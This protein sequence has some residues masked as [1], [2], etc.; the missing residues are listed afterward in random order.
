MARISVITGGAGGIGLACARRLA[1]AGDVVVLADLDAGRGEASARALREE[2]AEARFLPL[3]VS[4]EAAVAAFCARVEAEAGP[5]D[6]LVNSAGL[7]QNA[8]TQRRMDLA[9]HERLWRVNYDGTY[10]CSRAFGTR[11]CER[12]R[13]VICNLASINSFRVLPLPA[14][15]PGKAAIKSLTE[16]LCAEFGAAGVRV[17]AVAPGFT[18]TENLARRIEAGQR[19]PE[20]MKRYTALD[21]LITP[22][23]VA[24][25]VHFLC[26]EAA[27]MITGVTLPVDAGWLAALS[28]KTYP[29]EIDSED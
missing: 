11:M 23:D 1:R 15:T 25:A 27:R 3:D 8:Q 26:S 18:L 10:L 17:N 7:L 2:G 6:V 16:L 21:A 20:G 4:D 12:Q 13:G 22:E 14:Y 28:Y 9:Q 5:V 29:A 24:E 19:D